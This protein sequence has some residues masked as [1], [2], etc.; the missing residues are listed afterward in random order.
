MSLRA[1]N[2]AGSPGSTSAGAAI[3]LAAAHTAASGGPWWLALAE[4]VLG[5][6]AIC[7]E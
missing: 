6:L 7:M 2:A 1:A 5:A 4:L 3:I